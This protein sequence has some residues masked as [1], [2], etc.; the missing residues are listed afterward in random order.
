VAQ[1]QH[2]RIAAAKPS[3][4]AELLLCHEAES[5][6]FAVAT[7]RLVAVNFGMLD[8]SLHQ[9]LKNMEDA[10]GA[11][12]RRRRMNIYVGVVLSSPRRSP[13]S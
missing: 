11:D 9:Y 4:A 13:R 3:A 12:V 8:V 7:A 1:K 6:L 10:L 5:L 2:L